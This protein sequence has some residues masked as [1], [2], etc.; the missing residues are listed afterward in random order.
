[1]DKMWVNSADSHFLE[2]EDLWQTQLPS[3]L[4]ERMPRTERDGDW[5]TV[6]IDGRS[7]RRR[8]PNPALEEFR[9]ASMRP[10]E[11]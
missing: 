9:E 2:P 3:G 7:F 10:P 11:S 8:V 6:H 5:E 1:M 4:A